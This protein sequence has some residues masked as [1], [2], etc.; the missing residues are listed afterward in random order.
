MKASHVYLVLSG[1]LSLAAASAFTDALAAAPRCAVTC[2]LQTLP[3]TSCTISNETC[4]CTDPTFNKLVGGCVGQS[5]SIKEALTVQNLTWSACGFPLT[6]R[7]STAR[8]TMIFLFPLPVVF[9][10]I[11]LLAR[12]L[13]LSPWGAEDTAIVIAFT[14][15][16][17]RRLT[18]VLVMDYG[19][20]RDIWTLQPHEITSFLKIMFVLQLF[21][22]L[23]LAVIKASM[24]YLYLRVF[25]TRKF[26][27][28]LWAT[29]IFNILLGSAYVLLS[30]VQC[31]PLQH[32]WNGWDGEHTGKC[33]DLNTIGLT[34]VGFNIGLD[35]WMLILPLT[36]L[37][38]LK[39][40]RKKKIGVMAM[41]SVGIFL[42]S[43]SIVR[44]KS[45]LIFATTFN[46]TAEALWG[47]IWSYVELCVGIFVACM[48]AAR[49]LIWNLFPKLVGLTRQSLTRSS[50]TEPQSA[51]ADE[52]QL[53]SQG[54]SNPK[55]VETPAKAPSTTGSALDTITPTSATFTARS[56]R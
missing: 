48:P 7:T 41:F 39:L 8:Y 17:P 9:I 19:L 50:K 15:D 40:P 29:Q 34:H 33:A 43:V 20:G 22:I 6:D 49:Q 28:V 14:Y 55:E 23:D 38:K 24:L 1:S 51:T 5:C 53:I 4:L 16:A 35:V 11:R 13:R 2:A 32:Y 12:L 47:I 21:Y 54:Q 10:S 37:Y 27:T 36:Q 26:R 45:L 25:S 52:L 46:I 18:V 56:A 42:T 3:Q 30:L 44:I 31:Q